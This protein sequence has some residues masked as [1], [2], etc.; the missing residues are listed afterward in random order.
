[1]STIRQ[2]GRKYVS[3]DPMNAT[4]REKYNNDPDYRAQAVR[5]SAE[6]RAARSK[7]KAAAPLNAYCTTL[8]ARVSTGEY[9]R[10]G[11]ERKLVHS[12]EGSFVLCFSM[13]EIAGLVARES[14]TFSAW[15]Q[16]KFL[17]PPDLT[18]YSHRGLRITVYSQERA[19]RVVTA[20][21]QTIAGPKGHL[22]SRHKPRLHALQKWRAS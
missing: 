5:R 6:Y 8:L 7:A 4:R 21:A 22:R 15:V 14:A 17:M 10:W 2:P 16:N 12:K 1:M 13:E 19:A 20:F 11:T 3:S 18:V 9:K